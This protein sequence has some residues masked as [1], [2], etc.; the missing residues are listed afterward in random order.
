MTMTGRFAAWL[1]R[2][3]AAKTRYLHAIG[4]G[5]PG[6]TAPATL[7][8]WLRQDSEF[9]RA[10]QVARS[11]PP[12]PAEVIDLRELAAKMAAAEGR[13]PHDPPP[14]GSSEREIEQQG[15]KTSW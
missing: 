1:R 6:D 2:D 12:A 5:E 13:D 10:V 15:W 3:D 4:Q 7:R 11:N 8:E 9:A 14:P